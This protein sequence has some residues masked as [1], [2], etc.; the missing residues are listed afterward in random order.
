MFQCAGNMDINGGAFTVVNEQNGMTGAL[1]ESVVNRYSLT[2]I[3]E[4]VSRYCIDGSR[5]A[6]PMTP[7]NM[8]PHVTQI[9]AR[10]L[11]VTL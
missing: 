6:P 1:Y 4:K 8:H 5:T 7:P 11:L 3:Y 2:A 10:R 9:H